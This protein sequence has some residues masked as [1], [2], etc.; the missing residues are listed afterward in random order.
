MGFLFI[1]Y[2]MSDTTELLPFIQVD[3]KEQYLRPDEEGGSVNINEK[4]IDK[5]VVKSTIKEKKIYKYLLWIGFIVALIGFGLVIGGIIYWGVTNKS[6]G[7]FYTLMI[8]GAIL[9]FLGTIVA[10]V[11]G[12]M[13]HRKIK[14][15]V[16]PLR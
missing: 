14:H 2:K 7:W 11:S 4:N 5:K 12:T 10:L 15:E 1:C 16:S 6:D 9:V 3:Q 8:L 13:S